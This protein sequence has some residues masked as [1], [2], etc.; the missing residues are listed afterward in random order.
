MSKQGHK[1]S[2]Q[3][4]PGEG[5]FGPIYRSFLSPEKLVERPHE[6][7]HTMYELMNEARKRFGDKK[8]IA[9]R[10]IVD[11]HQEQKVVTKKIGDEEVKE[12]K[13]WTYYE[14]SPY[15]YI[16][17]NEFFKTVDEFAS[18]MHQLG[19]NQKT[20]FNIFAST[21]VSWQV[22]A[23]SCFRQGITFC[24]S[25]DTLGPEGL[26]V[27]LEEP[28]VQGIFTNA[29][30]LKVL[31]KIIDQT[32]LLRVVIYDGE[33]DENILNRIHS[34]ISGRPNAV[35]IHYDEV[36]RNGKQNMVGPAPTQGKDVACIMYTSGSTGK[37]KG[38]ILTNDNLIATI[39]SV[40]MLLK[41]YLNQSDSYLAYLPLAH[42]LEFV[43][44]CYMMYYGIAI[45]YGRVKTL[46]SNS[47]RKCEGDLVAFRPTLL[48]GV[49]AVW[50]LIRK[51]IV[52]KVQA[53][54][55]TKKKLFDMSMWAKSNN[56]P[57]FKQ[58][59]ESVV[60]KSVRAQTGGRIRY[61]LSGGAPIARETHQFL[62]TALTTIIQ[63]YGMTE[64]SAMCAL[65]TPEFFCYGSVGCPMPSVE[66]RLVDVPEA[67]YFANK[68]PAQGEVWIRGP[69]VTQG[70][71][72]RPEITEEAITKDGWLRT[73]D[74]GQWDEQGTLSLIDR[75]K[76]LVK[77][78]GGE[79]IALERLEST[80]KACNFV[81]NLCLVASS[82]AKQPMAVVFPREDNLRAALEDN[83]KKDIAH[84]ELSNLCHD[85]VVQN[86]MLK[87]LNEVGKE[88]GF[89]NMEL[90]Q[91]VV[92]IPEELP[93]TAA[94]KVQ[95]KEVEKK[96]ADLI[97][98]VYP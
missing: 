16:T 18:G 38:V 76:N 82:D 2:V 60:F 94:Q 96:Y 29:Q 61:A 10:D 63:G 50:E 74:I 8:N 81:S 73:G 6:G 84:L 32:P 39:A 41:P 68:N 70:Y 17:I 1:A 64:S 25:Y 65:M 14:L 11:E 75:K 53:A 71:F 69:S 30:H 97:K 23:Q 28:E 43:V 62:N 79:Y 86:M 40:T 56:I 59:A 95:R 26:Q 93:L 51:G 46:T 7:I 3:V 22:A 58:F 20:V 80:Y 92:L 89:A 45:G 35:L 66:V 21:N 24:T 52:S 36:I 15:K 87:K 78:S 31:E 33:A 67:G 90:L 44:E 54:S 27:S 91:C 42:I 55:A 49:P 37:P 9:W 5:A 19:L 4:S 57:L 47:V 12:T 13:T 98:K 72:K 88:A 77:L 48:V 34:K 83:N 85:K